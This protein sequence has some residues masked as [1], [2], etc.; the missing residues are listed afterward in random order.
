MKKM[1]KILR[2]ELVSVV[3]SPSF[4]FGAFGLPLIGTLIFWVASLLGQNIEASQAVTNL[5]SPSAG[6]QAEGYVD[7][8]GLIRR[9]PSGVPATLLRAYDDEAAARQAVDEGAIAA[10]YILPKDYLE[11]GKIIYIRPDFNPIGADTR[12]VL[13][14]EVIRFNLLEGDSQLAQRVQFPLNIE[15]KASSP[16]TQRDDNH[17]LTFFLPYAVTLIF[18]MIILTSASLLLSSVTKEKENR[19][20]EILMAST[21]AQQLLT[22]K[23]LGLGI[24]GLFQTL[25]WVGTGYTLL[26]LSGRTFDIPEAF[27]LPV[28]FIVWALIFFVLG[29]AIYAALM[30]GLGAL[31][32]NL[33]EAGQA[34]FVVI[35]P[36]FVPLILISVL[37]ED[38]NGTLATIL[39][40]IPLTA[41]VAMMT[42][43]S[44][45]SVPLWQP[46]L[47]SGLMVIT[48]VLIVRAVAGMFR[49]QTLLSGQSYSARRFL[50]A[51]AGRG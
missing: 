17:P 11:T 37:I 18:Y 45:G 49:A 33:K 2:Y 24:A 19:V 51:L 13:F 5:F 1:I 47:A 50:E 44:A 41:P 16:E 23:I 26:R 31:V 32:A 40:I 21:D 4:L 3:T 39:S 30:A 35:L 36:L 29:Y 14:R 48:A 25:A 7:E 12:S 10:F 9:L 8:M 46:A 43:L 38:S 20:I 22:G 28:S 15:V 27:Q 6:L 42:R 34:T